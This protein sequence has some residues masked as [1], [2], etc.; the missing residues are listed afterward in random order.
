[1]EKK[2]NE[3]YLQKMWKK[4]VTTARFALCQRFT[5]CSQQPYTTDFTADFDQAQSEDQGGLRRS[6]QTLDHLAT[7]RLLEQKCREWCIKMWVVTVDFMKA[8]VLTGSA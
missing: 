3:N 1:M 4:L 2:T 7:Y 5:S 8:P 6:Y